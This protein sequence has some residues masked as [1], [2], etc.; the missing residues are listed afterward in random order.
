MVMGTWPYMAPEQILGRSVD[1]RT[2]VFAF[3][4]VLYEMV[5]GR[6]PFL[7]DSPVAVASKQVLEQ[8]TPPSR[9]NPDV[10]PDL[11]AVILRALAKNPANRYGSAVDFRGDLER[12]RRGSPV[13]ATPL[14]PPPAGATQVIH[15]EP[16]ERTSLLSPSELEPERSRWWIPVLVTLLIL[17]VLG[18]CCSSSR[19]TGRR[20]GPRAVARPS[21]VVGDRFSGPAGPSRTRGSRS[22]RRRSPP[23]RRSSPT[24]SRAPW[25]SRTRPRTP[26]WRRAR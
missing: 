16:A 13:E 3:G 12:I 18:A 4:V 8:P 21:N 1:A 22:R 25:S 24:P 9:L 11:D 10:S 19:I 17:A 20:R 7:G 26:R 23:R 15:R 5:T 14:L 2:D 6:P